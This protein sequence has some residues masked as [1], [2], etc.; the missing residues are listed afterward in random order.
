MLEFHYQK[1][2]VWNYSKLT[3]LAS[4]LKLSKQKLQEWLFKR[5]KK[6]L[7]QNNAQMKRV[8]EET[9]NEK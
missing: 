5:Q 1:Y 8:V 4:Q 9:E 7:K 3:L 6:E 2:P